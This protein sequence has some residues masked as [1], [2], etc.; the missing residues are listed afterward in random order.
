VGSSP[1]LVDAVAFSP[2]TDDATETKFWS[3]Y[4]CFDTF[5]QAGATWRVFFGVHG[6]TSLA[7]H[8]LTSLRR[9][10]P[11]VVGEK[12]KCGGRF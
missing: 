4:T 7:V 1:V 8:I 10:D 3:Y 6:G 9:V 5:A 12:L 2:P 11:D